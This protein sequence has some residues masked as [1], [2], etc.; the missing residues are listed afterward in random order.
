ML[1][2]L[3]VAC[4]LSR[5]RRRRPGRLFFDDVV[6]AL[7]QQRNQAPSGCKM[8][9]NQVPRVGPSMKVGAST[10]PSEQRRVYE[11]TYPVKGVIDIQPCRS[12]VAAQRTAWDLCVT[13]QV[14]PGSH[15]GSTY[16]RSLAG[17]NSLSSIR[18]SYRFSSDASGGR[19]KAF[20]SP[21]GQ[22]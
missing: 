13:I 5:K 4:P 11:Y 22:V 12:S 10:R 18:M 14:E 2:V 15:P 21:N 8:I 7:L 6:P 16:L 1:S 19:T 9:D 3:T 17:R 20:R